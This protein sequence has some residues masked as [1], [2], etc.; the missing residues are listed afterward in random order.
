[1]IS[2][3]LNKKLQAHPEQWWNLFPDGLS[4]LIDK[5]IRVTT[6]DIDKKSVATLSP[7]VEARSFDFM[8]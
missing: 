1:M 6:N 7:L 8:S 4:F 5:Y 3:C 2:I